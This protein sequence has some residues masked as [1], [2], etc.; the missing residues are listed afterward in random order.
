MGKFHGRTS[1]LKDSVEKCQ[2]QR[3]AF[4]AVKEPVGPLVG[5]VKKP[6]LG[7]G[8][9]LLRDLLDVIAEVIV[10]EHPHELAEVHIGH[11]CFAGDK[12][13]VFVIVLG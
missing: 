7:V 4:A 1:E 3:L 11:F 5:F 8:L 9:F 10:V 12:E 2:A 13:L 6:R